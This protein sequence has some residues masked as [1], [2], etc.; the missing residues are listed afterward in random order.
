MSSHDKNTPHE[1]ASGVASG[2]DSVGDERDEVLPDTTN[3]DGTPI[4]N[5]SGG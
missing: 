3:D 2:E 4:D 5:P 1:E